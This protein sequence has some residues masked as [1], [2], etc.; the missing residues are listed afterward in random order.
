MDRF[1]VRGP[2]ISGARHGRRWRRGSAL[3]VA[4]LLL[5]AGA[6]TAAADPGTVGEWRFDES[7][8]QTALDRGPFGLDGRLGAG[9]DV[10]PADPRRIPGIAGGA[11]GFGGGSFVR[12]PDAPEL[13]QPRLSVEA[14]V[15][16]GGSP[17]AYRYLVS[18]GGQGCFAGSY[19]LYTARTGGVAFY[20]FDGSGYVVS[21]TARVSDVWDG[22]WHHV[23]GTFD[24][25]RLRLY[26]DG[27][28]VG[29]PSHGPTRIDWSS[30][31][32]SAAIGRYVGSCD[33]SFAGDLDLVRLWSDALSPSAVAVAAATELHPGMPVDPT[34]LPPLP[35]GD[36]PTELPAKPP[37]GAPEATPGAPARACAMGISRRRIVARKSTAVRVRVTVRGR[38]QRSV[39]VVARQSGHRKPIT[40]GRTGKRGRARL[41]LKARRPGTVR[42][43]ASITPSCTP[44]VITV[45]RP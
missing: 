41:V 32:S 9:D 27:R 6:Q 37:A 40:Q 16:A 31:S 25:G 11:L 14:V 21:A 1:G 42:I 12:L 17:G 26:V 7:A 36:P 44:G 10:D 39:K 18:R 5:A 13:A 43:S 8:G 3:L 29:D 34:P 20:A 23:A 38:P 35:A 24:G 15:R 4:C 28:P 30:T 19:G 2:V 22:A 45:V 33:L